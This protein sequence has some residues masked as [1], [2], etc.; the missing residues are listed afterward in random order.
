MILPWLMGIKKRHPSSEAW[1]MTLKG[2][3]LPERDGWAKR[4]KMV[5][6]SATAI[7]AESVDVRVVDGCV[8]RLTFLPVTVHVASQ[9]CN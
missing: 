1:D 8:T 5:R 9:T 6:S 3:S 7:Q 4:T 2:V